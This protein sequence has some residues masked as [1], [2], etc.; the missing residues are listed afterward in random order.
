MSMPI[1]APPVRTAP[2]ALGI[3]L[4][5]SPAV[6]LVDGHGC[7]A[8]PILLPDPGDVQVRVARL[9][10]LLGDLIQHHRHKGLRVVATEKP[11]T[12]EGD[13]RRR[14]GMNQMLLQG[15]VRAACIHWDLE[16][17]EVAPQTVKASFVGSGRAGK[18]AVQAAVRQRY[19]IDV[20]SLTRNTAMLEHL[21]DC[22]AIAHCALVRY[23]TEQALAGQGVLAVGRGRR[24]RAAQA[25]NL[26]PRRAAGARG[27]AR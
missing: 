11:W 12:K 23:S 24:R 21:A 2:L 3:D 15:V 6:A 1:P 7:V 17:R 16:F 10:G 14:A 25:P 22:V 18:E 26:R 5:V 4:G 13:R 19:G 8:G 9:W 20:R 27:G